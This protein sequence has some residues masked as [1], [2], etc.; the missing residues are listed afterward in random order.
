MCP[1][2]LLMRKVLFLLLLALLPAAPLADRR[3][4]FRP[5]AVPLVLHD[6]YFSIWSFNDRLTDGPTRHWTGTPQ[7]LRSMVLVDGQPYRILGAD[8]ARDPASQTPPL[9]QTFVQ[10]LPTRT[11]YEFVGAGVRLRLT[12]LTPDFPEDLDLLARPVTYIIWN[13]QSADGRPHRVS[14]YFD[15]SSVLAVNDRSEPV[16]WARFRLDGAPLLRAGSR[17][18][19]ML[20]KK[21]DN[22]RI[23][24]GYLYVL[25]APGPGVS[26]VIAGSRAAWEDFHHSGQLPASDIL[27]PS[28]PA[29][30]LFPVLAAAF[31]LGDV[32]AAPVERH[33]LLAYDEVYSIE[34]LHR[35]LR[36]YWRR[37]GTTAADMLRSALRDFPNL[38]TRSET[39]DHDLMADLQAAGGDHYALLAALAYRQAI[40]AHAFTVDADGQPMLF[41]KENFSNGC[42]STVDVIYPSSPLFL[43]LNPRL[44][45]ALLR[46]VFEY[47]ALPRW[48]FPFAPHDLGTYPL[49]DGQVY[50]GGE[51]SADDQM[52]VEESGNLLI[53]AAAVGRAEGNPSF[54]EKYWPL[55]SRWAEYLK[56]KGFDPENQLST[57]DFAGHLAHNANLSIKAILAL[58][59]FAWL[60]QITGR[61]SAADSYRSLAEADARRWVQVDNDGDHFRLAFDQPGTWS[62]KYNLVW[63]RIFGFHLFSPSVAATEVEFYKNHLQPFGMPLD[64]RRL[65]TKL[66]WLVWTATLADSPSDFQLLADGAYRFADGTPDRVPLSDWYWTDSG[67]HVGFQAR[68]VVGGI[69][70]KMLTDSALWRKWL[71][72]V[73]FSGPAGQPA[74]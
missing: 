66:D 54:A 11:V 4:S 10:V 58:R 51:I 73:G 74:H 26:T 29:R 61:R 39:F 5:P 31:D 8:P 15:A 71:T 70:I 65:Y 38:E 37:N 64:N 36:P 13:V 60:C 67:K 47:A 27:E 50:G 59:A 49:A 55:L 35:R 42:I 12:F 21:G 53:L 44:V 33:L 17:Q 23:D 32:S 69:Y 52:P 3:S 57:D 43:L 41:P 1:G 30:P 24:W 6:P 14:I 22:L 48:K 34:Y 9:K 62:M 16:S 68:S 46:P 2:S 72:R 20:E 56:Q 40:A 7:P 45:E 19:P 63:D 28:T 18:Q 25:P